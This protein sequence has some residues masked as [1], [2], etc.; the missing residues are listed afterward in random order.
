MKDLIRNSIEKLN[1]GMDRFM[2]DSLVLAF[3]LSVITFIFGIVA[4]GQTPWQMVEH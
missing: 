2:P 1:F 3:A 4:A